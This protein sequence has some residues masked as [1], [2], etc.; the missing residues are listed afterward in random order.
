MQVKNKRVIH[1]FQSQFIYAWLLWLLLDKHYIII[2]VIIK[3][4]RHD[5]VIV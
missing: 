3:S 1:K 4:E 5:N 2:I